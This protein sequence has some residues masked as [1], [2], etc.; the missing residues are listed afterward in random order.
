[1]TTRAAATHCNETSGRTSK[2][3]SPQSGDRWGRHAE[4]ARQGGR[5]AELNRRCLSGTNTPPDLARHSA[6]KDFS[7]SNRSL[8]FFPIFEPKPKKPPEA[9]ATASPSP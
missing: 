4:N 3:A 6:S 1:M 7:V 8:S 2:T 5:R 9:E